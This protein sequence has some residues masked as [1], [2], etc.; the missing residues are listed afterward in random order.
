[1]VMLTPATVTEK[2]LA[3]NYGHLFYVVSCH[4][5]NSLAGFLEIMQRVQGLWTILSP[6]TLSS[7]PTLTLY[8]Q[9]LSSLPASK[10]ISQGQKLRHNDVADTLLRKRQF[11]MGM[12]L[13]IAKTTERTSRHR[14]VP[15]K[16]VLR[17]VTSIVRYSA[18]H[19]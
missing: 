9:P 3:V 5:H 10:R 15:I 8:T 1:M 4:R 17:S 18:I 14:T 2:I 13:M 12:K 16:S 6:Q 7:I 19:L 11:Q